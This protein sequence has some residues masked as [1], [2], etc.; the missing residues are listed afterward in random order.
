VVFQVRRGF[1]FLW[2][3]LQEVSWGGVGGTKA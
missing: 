1:S 2:H 3:V